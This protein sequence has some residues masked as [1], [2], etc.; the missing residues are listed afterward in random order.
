MRKPTASKKVRE[1]AAAFAC[2]LASHDGNADRHDGFSQEA[3]DL[4]W[5]TMIWH[6]HHRPGPRFSMFRG[7]GPYNYTQCWGEVGSVIMNG[8]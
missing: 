1:E 8:D 4:F 7:P 3:V 5:A 6:M 2:V